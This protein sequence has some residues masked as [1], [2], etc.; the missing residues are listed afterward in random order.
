MHAAQGGHV[1]MIPVRGH[2]WR[3]ESNPD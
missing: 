1:V 3:R 2:A